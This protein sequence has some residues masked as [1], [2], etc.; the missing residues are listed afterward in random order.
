L[1]FAFSVVCL[2]A[3][4]SGGAGLITMGFIQ[5]C[6]NQ[7]NLEPLNLV[8]QSD[9]AAGCRRRTLERFQFG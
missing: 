5:G 4:H 7:I 1:I 2:T 6:A 9:L 8:V 3:Q